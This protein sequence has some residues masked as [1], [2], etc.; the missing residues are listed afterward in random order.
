MLKSQ[1]KAAEE[2]EKANQISIEEFL[3]VE[4]RALLLHGDGWYID[5]G[6]SA[7]NWART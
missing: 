3:E 2:A 6:E 1:R 7:T 4:V 5:S